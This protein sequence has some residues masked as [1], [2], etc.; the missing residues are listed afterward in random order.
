MYADAAKRAHYYRMQR[1]S[2]P[3]DITT[4]DI[5]GLQRYLS[6][7]LKAF[8]DI[9]AKIRALNGNIQL[10]RAKKD[11]ISCGCRLLSSLTNIFF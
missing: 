11:E 3:V 1:T 2:G 9:A 4:D 5:G 8:D 6:L 7:E 10:E